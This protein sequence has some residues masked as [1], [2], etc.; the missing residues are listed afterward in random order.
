MMMTLRRV[1]IFV[2]RY[3]L[4]GQEEKK[5]EKK[6]CITKGGKLKLGFVIDGNYRKFHGGRRGAGL[7]GCSCVGRKRSKKQ[8]SCNRFISERAIEG[9]RERELC[10]FK[11]A[12]PVY[13]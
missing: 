11:P 9:Y 13:S 12:G 5:R 1:G 4:K 3:L 8:H 2:I 10:V 6:L 7:A